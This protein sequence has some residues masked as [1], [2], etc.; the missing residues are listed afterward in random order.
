MLLYEGE[1]VLG[2]RD[3]R[4]IH[5]PNGWGWH[6]Y[7]D[8]RTPPPKDGGAVELWEGYTGVSY[9][10]RWSE[11]IPVKAGNEYRTKVWVDLNDNSSW[12]DDNPHL[13]PHYWRYVQ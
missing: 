5:P 8:P 2:S 12:V 4:C 11:N 13:A 1:E 7:H 9:I 3:P 10:M 6:D